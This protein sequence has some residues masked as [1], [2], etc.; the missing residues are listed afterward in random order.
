M[1]RTATFIT[2]TTTTNTTA[3]TSYSTAAA[4]TNSIQPVNNNNN[5]NNNKGLKDVEVGGRVET[6]QTL[7]RTARI[8]RRVLETCGDM[9]HPKFS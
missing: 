8:L 2:T 5:N 9:L 7:L 4:S 1:S 6:I 3:T